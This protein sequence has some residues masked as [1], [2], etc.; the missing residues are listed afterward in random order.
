MFRDFPKYPS[1][2]RCVCICSLLVM[3]LIG[4]SLVTTDAVA[5]LSGQA[6]LKEYT[7]IN[8]PACTANDV[9]ISVLTVIGGPP[10]C[11]PG[12]TL[13]LT[14]EATIES[15]PQRFDIGLWLNESGG[16][17]QTDP[18]GTCFR[19]FLAPPLSAPPGCDQNGGPYANLDGDQCGD[20]PAVGAAS[21]CSNIV[22]GPCSEGGG[23]CLSSTRTFNITL[24]CNDSD[25]D[26][27]ADV[28]TCTSWDNNDNTTCN[29][30]L[31]AA[32]G[33]GS[34][35]SCG[36]VP[37]GEIFI[38]P[39]AD[40]DCDDGNACTADSCDG[41][42][43]EAV[44]VNDP[45][46]LN[47]TACGDPTDTVCDNPD[48]CLD[49]VCEP[50]YEPSGTE[51][52]GVAGVCDVAEFCD[53]AGSCPSDSF[54]PGTTLCRSGSGD[55]C[56]PD[57]FCSGFGP[58]CPS[59]TVSP[60]GTVCRE[61]AG[62][63]DPAEE[64]SGVAGEPCPGDGKSTDECRASG[65]VCDP[66]EVC[67]GVNN[68]CPA[69]Q[70]STDECRASGG[71]CDP[72]EVCDG[73]NNDCP[74]DQKSTD[75]CRASGGVCDP[76]EVCDGINN[77]CPADQKSTDVCREASGECDA[78]ESCDGVSNDC[79]ADESLPDGT[80]C[81]DTDGSACTT[82]ACQGGACQQDNETV[83]CTDPTC[84]VCDPGTG[85]CGPR[86]PLP[87]VCLFEAICR[88][89]GFFGTHAGT[90]KK[91]SLN[92][93]QALLD[94]AGGIEVCGIPLNNTTVNSASSAVEALCV[95]IEGDQNLQ[96][97]RQLTALALSCIVSGDGGDCT[98]LGPSVSDLFADCNLACV[99]DESAV[100]DVQGCIDEVDCF[101]NGGAFVD[102][103]C[104][105]GVCSDNGAFCN[106]DNLTA[107]DVP[108]C[109]PLDLECVAATCD[110]IPG[111]CHDRELCADPEG[112]LCFEPPGP[113]G[114][115]SACNMA[116][117]NTC[118]VTNAASCANP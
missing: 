39:C 31:D 104:Y 105:L 7:G 33:T 75:E 106:S 118:V 19:D 16:S 23:T 45:D 4:F 101:N 86:D 12:E 55:S 70:K 61:S 84:E 2:S 117:S 24:T 95:S 44:C 103:F 34:K 87:D 20:V 64:C 36:F 5:Q 82:P 91:N 38:N 9:R 80:P 41:S 18:D 110:P 96:L 48:T 54:E 62:V 76:A 51:C 17:A 97:V 10:T 107:C 90:S 22:T 81:V 113:A 111:N 92:I 66:A 99:G 49:G 21:T 85:V 6:C 115:S 56:D 47:G 27:L 37:V 25:G 89:P 57:E 67:D 78:T 28:G 53:G 26:G 77:D 43:G 29:G 100:R 116:T 83:T 60:G 59:D 13:N 8:N 69:D 63:C 15:G 50:N 65:G 93:T 3:G 35:C 30:V 108:S 112:D 88:T 72:A 52:R 73:V 71:V 42:S 98:G 102:G 40:V 74:A 109:D 58:D 68:D 14:V 114:S 11:M 94:S 79:P 46:P 1:G 32:P